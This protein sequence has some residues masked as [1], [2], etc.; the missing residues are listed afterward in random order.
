MAR[1][2]S[3]H[4]QGLNSPLH[5]LLLAAVIAGLVVAGSTVRFLSRDLQSPTGETLHFAI[6]EFKFAFGSGVPISD[7]MLVD[8]FVNG[9]ALLSSGQVS[10]QASEAR[11]LNYT[12]QPP[13]MNQEAAF[14]WRRSDDAQNVL[15]TD[16]TVTG[17]QKIDL[18]NEPEWQGEITEFG[19]LLAGTNGETGALADFQLIPDSLATRLTL[20]WHAWTVFEPWSQQSINF[21]HGGDHRKL[22][23]LPL[24]IA[25]WLAITVILFW[26]LGRSRNAISSKQFF[27]GGFILFLV[28]WVTLD[29]RWSIN[30]FRQ[31]Q[32]SFKT[33]WQLNDE[34][35]SLSALDGDI[36]RYI[37]TLKRNVIDGEQNRILIVGDESS[38]DYYLLRA[39]YHLLP[40]SVNVAG[41]FARNLGPEFIDYVIYF[42]QHANITKTTGWTSSWAEALTIVDDGEWGVVYKTTK[43]PR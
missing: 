9:Y 24:L 7:R 19:F 17:T 14:F 2:K 33:H 18:F 30:N 1:R 40:H 35:R 5:M 12:W 16:I 29:I 34:Q 6:S 22:V 25:N 36:Y 27:T 23:A 10:I 4:R 21:L 41:G 3:D 43:G 13:D 31:I 42:G 37:Q 20:S 32:H 15:R 39:K 26:L 28:A 38:V 8:K 11:V